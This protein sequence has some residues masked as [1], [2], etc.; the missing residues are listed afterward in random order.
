M[1]ILI[2]ALIA[3]IASLSLLAIDHQKCQKDYDDAMAQCDAMEDSPA[4]DACIYRATYKFAECSNGME[5][6]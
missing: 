6:I 3:V 5:S 2:L 1:K 4:K